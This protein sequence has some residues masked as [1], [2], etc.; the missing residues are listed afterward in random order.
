MHIENLYHE[1]F[2][3]TIVEQKFNTSNNV[4]TLTVCALI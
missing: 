4:S 3:L 2:G 1:I